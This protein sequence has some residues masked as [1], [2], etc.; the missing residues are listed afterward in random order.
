MA[1]LSIW[2]KFQ[3]RI[4]FGYRRGP[5]AAAVG[6]TAV[7]AEFQDFKK[8]FHLGE[9]QVKTNPNTKQWVSKCARG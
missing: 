1:Y 9:D 7:P 2:G 5:P 3:P 6:S 4:Y 8:F